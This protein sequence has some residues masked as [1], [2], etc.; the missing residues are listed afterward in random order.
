MQPSLE[1]VRPVDEMFSIF[2]TVL[3]PEGWMD[4]GPVIYFLEKSW[5]KEERS[6]WSRERLIVQDVVKKFLHY[7]LYYWKVDMEFIE[8]SVGRIL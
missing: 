7:T 4:L 2:F 5:R 6:C 1:V 8:T 3:A